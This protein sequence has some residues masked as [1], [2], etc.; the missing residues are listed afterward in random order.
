MKNANNHMI[1][2]TLG[3][4]SSYHVQINVGLERGIIQ[5]LVHIVHIKER[6]CFSP[7]CKFKKA[8][9]KFEVK[10]DLQKALRFKHFILTRNVLISP[11]LRFHPFCNMAIVP[12]DYHVHSC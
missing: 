9:N 4:D 3:V 1:G 11:N 10:V 6:C 8:I 12:N 2:P 5:A 7:L